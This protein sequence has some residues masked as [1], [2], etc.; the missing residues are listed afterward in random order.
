MNLR[1]MTGRRYHW[2][3]ATLK[4]QIIQN[5]PVPEAF[6][7]SLIT[8]FNNVNSYVL[9]MMNIDTINSIIKDLGT[10]MIE[11]FNFSL[12]LKIDIIGYHQILINLRSLEILWTDMTTSRINHSNNILMYEHKKMDTKK[13]IQCLRERLDGSVSSFR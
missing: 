11:L 12:P 9:S 4:Q 6:I 7:T 10:L 5:E 3:N 13:I 8:Y 1:L 2:K